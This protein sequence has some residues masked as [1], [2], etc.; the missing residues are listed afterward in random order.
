MADDLGA[1]LDRLLLQ[2]RQRSVLDRLGRCQR[3]LKVAEIVCQRVKLQTLHMAADIRHDNRIH[4]IAPL[5][6]L[7]HCS[8]ALRLL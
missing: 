1:D 6:S 7:I 3:A 4:L 2:A 5:A 8:Q